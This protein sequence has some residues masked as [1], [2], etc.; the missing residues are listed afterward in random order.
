MADRSDFMQVGPITTDPEHIKKAVDDALRLRGVEQHEVL[1]ELLEAI[2]SLTT[3]INGLV[4]F[5]QM[6][7]YRRTYTSP[8]QAKPTSPV[9]QRPADPNLGRP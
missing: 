7:N 3:A 6:E 8:A 5:M 4:D 2:H 1:E 9:G